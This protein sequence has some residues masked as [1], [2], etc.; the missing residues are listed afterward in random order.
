MLFWLEQYD[1]RSRMLKTIT[2]TTRRFALSLLV[3]CSNTP[4]ELGWG[5]T[6]E[7]SQTPN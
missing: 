3:F 4:S 2:L 6:R 5:D 1:E 7:P